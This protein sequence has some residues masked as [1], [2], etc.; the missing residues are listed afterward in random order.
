M[1]YSR[2]L[3]V[4]FLVL[5]ACNSGGG[6]DASPELPDA[7]GGA[8]ATFNWTIVDSGV[9]STCAS[10]DVDEVNIEA[11]PEVGVPVLHTFQCVL[12]PGTLAL[13]PG[14]YAI[15]AKLYSNRN[16]QTRAFVPAQPLTVPSSGTA[17]AMTFNFTL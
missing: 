10:V 17:P 9:P 11:T 5:A 15:S 7:A 16:S 2:S 3:L 6:D 4:A 8:N 1:T 12:L 14:R 13:A